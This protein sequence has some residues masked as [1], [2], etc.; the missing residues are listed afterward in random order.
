MQCG[1]IRFVLSPKAAAAAS[2]FEHVVVPR[3][4]EFTA[5]PRSTDSGIQVLYA[6]LARDERRNVK[7]ASDVLEAVESGRSPLV[8]TERTEQV[9]DLARLLSDRIPH[10]IELRGG[11][12]AARREQVARQLDAVPAD[13]PRVLIATGRYVGEGF[14]DA[15]LDTLFLAM[16]ISWRG[17]LQ[18]Y[19]G[20]LHRRYD[21]KRVVRVYDYVDMHVPVLYRMYEKRLRGYAAIGYSIE[22]KA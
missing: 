7:I 22:T 6:A 21:S 13:E 10:V 3:L 8:L 14:D 1:L 19:V 2:P 4:T 11:L 20:R 9:R 18:Q 5:E 15:R 12:S 16:P 17:T